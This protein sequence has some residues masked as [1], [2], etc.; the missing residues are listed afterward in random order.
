MNKENETTTAN[1]HGPREIDPELQAWLDAYE[2]EVSAIPERDLE[3][4]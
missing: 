2:A 4:A 1:P 3:C